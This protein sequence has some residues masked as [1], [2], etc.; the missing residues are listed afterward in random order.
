VVWEGAG[1][2]PCD[3]SHEMIPDG[4]HIIT[5]PSYRPELKPI[6]IFWD[7]IQDHTSNKLWPTIKC[8]DQVVASYL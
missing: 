3:S 1:F 6:E 8:M 4:I 7:L 5:F 2:H